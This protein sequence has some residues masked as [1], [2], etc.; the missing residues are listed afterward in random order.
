MSNVAFRG[1]T[2][3]IFVS[4][5]NS[6]IRIAVV[7]ANERSKKQIEKLLEI[8]EFNLVGF[9]DHD[10]A[11]SKLLENTYSISRF[12]DFND[13]IRSA[14]AISIQSPIGTHYQYA[15]KAIRNLK[16]VFVK[17]VLSENL[18]EAKELNQ[19]ADEANVQ[20][21][22]SHSQKF[23]PNYQLLKRLVDDPQYIECSRFDEKVLNYS[24]ENLV[25]DLLL[26]DLELALNMVKSKVMRVRATG[27]CLHSNLVDF[28]NV[29]I[30][31]ANGCVL[32]MVC[33]NFKSEQGNKMK[34]FQRNKVF[35]LDLDTFKISM[36]HSSESTEPE[37]I[38]KT[39]KSTRQ[40]ADIVKREL[41]YFA[42]SIN[43]HSLQLRTHSD[44]F[45]TLELCH[46]IIER[47]NITKR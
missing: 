9:Y 16:H 14:D 35:G 40:S 44:N 6:M 10:E 30:E 4:I 41:E 2:K 46:L 32:N 45:D 33:G 19:L 23:H 5:I 39:G 24:T 22:V 13:L 37:Q 3:D 1:I 21:Y 34:F 47:L 26:T 20:L 17:Q 18:E 12:D 36:L 28:I 15:S 43:N 42:Q 29:R 7:G 8:R 31:F 38:L 27:A 25:F 11:S